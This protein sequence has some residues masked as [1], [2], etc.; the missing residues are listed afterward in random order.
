MVQLIFFALIGSTGRPSQAVGGTA[1][2][3]CIQV[4]PPSDPLTNLD[5]NYLCWVRKTT[6]IVIQFSRPVMPLYK[7]KASVAVAWLSR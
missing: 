5:H 4:K 7:G 3:T 1:A 2:H 6:N